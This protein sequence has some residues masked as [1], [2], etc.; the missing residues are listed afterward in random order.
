VDGRVVRTGDV[1][2]DALRASVRRAIAPEQVAGWPL[3]AGEPFFLATLQRPDLVNDPARLAGVL[4][5]LADAPFPVVL[6][7]HR[8]TRE[9]LTR[10]GLRGSASA[11]VHLLPP[12]GYLEMLGCLQR[13]TALVT[14]SGG[15][16][17]D[18]YWLGTPCVTLR[19][20]TEWTETV[21]VGANVL[22][23][24]EEV[25]ARLPA[26]LR[27]LAFGE[28]RPTWNRDLYGDGYAADRVRDAVEACVGAATAGA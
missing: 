8:R 13:A 5:A 6:P 3:Q 2:R 15:A 22:V 4:A 12:L 23:P 28:R 25:G 27:Q 20:E 21:T 7:L 14:D 17:R 1:A 18:A 19:R 24:V 11:R 16:Q 10:H 26:R 9:C